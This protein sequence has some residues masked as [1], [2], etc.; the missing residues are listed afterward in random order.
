MPR[1]QR[2]HYGDGSVYADKATG[3]FIAQIYVNG[4]SIRR[5]AASREAAEALLKELRLQRDTGIDMTAAAQTIAAFSEVWFNQVVLPRNLKMNTNRSYKGLLELYVVPDLGQYRLDAPR[6]RDMQ[7]YINGLSARNTIYGTPFATG[8]INQIYRILKAMYD[9][10]VKWE[11]VIRNP[12][13]GV[14]CPSAVHKEKH[15]MTIDQTR[16]LWNEAEGSRYAAIY[17][18]MSVLGLRTGEALGVRWIDLNR[19]NR[20]IAIRQQIQ[21]VKGGAVAITP[22]TKSSVRILP[23]TDDLLDRIDRHWTF[24]QEERARLGIE[25]KEHGLIFPGTHGAPCTP[26]TLRSQYL[27]IRRR[28]DL[29]SFGLHQLRHTAATRL[30][31]SGAHPYIIAAILGHAA[32][33]QTQDYSDVSLEAMRGAVEQA[34]RLLQTETQK[35]AEG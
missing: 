2:R 34:E 12:M 10:A 22:K 20:S 19:A 3:G 27:Y 8:T 35:K 17:P 25:W 28:C 16:Q 32:Q 6:P 13:D 9:T 14:D 33:T 4:K 21:A 7:I 5:R 15:A 31:E 24:Q 18:L 11:Y 1:K 23:L 26:E 29:V 30:M